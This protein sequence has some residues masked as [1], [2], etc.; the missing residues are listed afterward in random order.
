MRVGIIV[1]VAIWACMRF[2]EWKAD[3]DPECNVYKVAK[4]EKRT[5]ISKVWGAVIALLLA[6]F[7]IIITPTVR[8][9]SQDNSALSDDLDFPSSVR[10]SFK[11]KTLYVPF[12]YKG[13]YCEP[14][15]RYILLNETDSAFVLYPTYFFNGTFAHAGTVDKFIDV[16]VHSFMK[17]LKGINNKFEKPSDTVTGYVSESERNKETTE[18]PCFPSEITIVQGTKTG[19]AVLP[20]NIG[21]EVFNPNQNKRVFTTLTGLEKNRPLPGR[22]TVYGLK[23]LNDLRGGVEKDTLRIAVYQGDDSAEGKTAALYEYVSDVLITGDDIASYIPKDSYLNVTINV[24]RSEMMSVVCEFPQTGQKV[25]KP[26]DTSKRQADRSVEYL[27]DLLENAS[28]QVRNLRDELGE[29]D[30]SSG[31]SLQIEQVEE[32][33]NAGGQAKQIE[34]HLKEILRKVEEYAN[35]SK[36]DLC[37]D[38][39]RS[40]L[41]SLRIQAAKKSGDERVARMVDSF[42]LQVER[43]ADLKDEMKARYLRRQIEEYEYAICRD[44]IYRDYIRYAEREFS[45]IKWADVVMAQQLVIEGTML[46]KNNP[47]ATYEQTKDIVDTLYVLKEC[48][49]D[50]EPGG[51]DFSSGKTKRSRKVPRIDIPSM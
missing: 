23:T 32:E 34:Q 12:Y 14:F 46:L 35:C 15:G 24:D 25:E 20:Y 18:V 47:N 40:A 13:H 16:P 21:I 41:F 45:E 22:G 30:I 49:D 11:V 39:L 38:R 28:T 10:L 43:M 1:Y 48:Y 37:L 5:D 51:S 27:R 2:R 33:M 42:E 31:L 7:G 6:C 4:Y 26:L 8:V 17:W 9:V 50:V 3:R 29:S 19:S 44:E 36:W